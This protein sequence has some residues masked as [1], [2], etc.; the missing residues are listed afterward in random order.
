MN[1]KNIFLQSP[2]SIGLANG[3]E[4]KVIGTDFH[5]IIDA[6]NLYVGVKATTFN[7]DVFET[8]RCYAAG[9]W[10]SIRSA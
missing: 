10:T 3:T 4:D 9:F 2:F 8:E 5:A 7:G 1:I 6:G